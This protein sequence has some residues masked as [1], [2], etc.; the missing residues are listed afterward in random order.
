[1]SASTDVVRHPVAMSC[2]CG[3]EWTV[4]SAVPLAELRVGERKFACPDCG[5]Q[6]CYRPVVAEDRRCTECNGPLNSYTPPEED[7]CGPC[8]ETRLAREE[9][10]RAPA[11]AEARAEERRHILSHLPGS[12]P[13]VVKTSGVRWIDCQRILNEAV[14]AGD[15]VQ[16]NAPSF[17]PI[18]KLVA[19]LGEAPEKPKPR[20]T[21]RNQARGVPVHSDEQILALLPAR[22]GE[23]VEQLGLH[24]N[25][26]TDRMG[27]MRWKGLVHAERR[28]FTDRGGYEYIY[29]RVE[30]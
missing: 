6:C 24:K 16:W 14:R 23:L 26:V 29:H 27:R 11:V 10:E 30:P 20:R 5:K 12:L 17:R 25:T 13:W 18:Y 15:V 28:T 9:A 19:D 2:S 22:T 4:K 8:T 7:T 1:M 21:I 3:R